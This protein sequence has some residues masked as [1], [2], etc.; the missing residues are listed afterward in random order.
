MF[1]QPRLDDCHNSHR[2]CKR[3]GSVSAVARHSVPRDRAPGLCFQKL[4]LPSAVAF[5]D[6][7]PRL[8]DW[9]ACVYYRGMVTYGGGSRPRVTVRWL[10]AALK[11]ELRPAL[12]DLP[13]IPGGH[14]CRAMWGEDLGRVQDG[15]RSSRALIGRNGCSSSHGRIETKVWVWYGTAPAK[16]CPGYGHGDGVAPLPT[17]MLWHPLLP[18]HAPKAGDAPFHGLADQDACRPFEA[19]QIETR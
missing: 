13:L 8:G 18:R 3:P 7:P 1:R 4:M 14:P 9:C 19:H 6:K 12:A 16:A 17:G 5:V 2:L 10:T 15:P 11:A